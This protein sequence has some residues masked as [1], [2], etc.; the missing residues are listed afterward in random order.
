MSI[1]AHLEQEMVGLLSRIELIEERNSRENRI[2]APIILGSRPI[3]ADTNS[4]WKVEKEALLGRVRSL[5]ETVS[6]MAKIQRTLQ[7][8]IEELSVLYSTSENHG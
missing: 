7:S 6:H 3:V 2:G 4:N 5:E 8:A 1:L